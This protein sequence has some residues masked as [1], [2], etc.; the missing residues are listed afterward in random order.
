QAAADF[1]PVMNTMKR[2]GGFGPTAIAI[3]MFC[4][5]RWSLK[6]IVDLTK[7]HRLGLVMFAIMLGLF[8]GFRSALAVS[9][10]VMLIQFF[11]EGLHRTRVAFVTL[12][13]GTVFFIFLALFA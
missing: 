5:A 11:A 1:E 3:M 7:P 10:I 4:L 6:G 2:Y 12:G 8:S 13:I 9:A